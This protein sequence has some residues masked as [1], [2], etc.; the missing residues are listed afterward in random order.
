MGSRR[1]ATW[2]VVLLEE[3]LGKQNKSE[4]QVR[5]LDTNKNPGA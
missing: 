5:V 4:Q 1:G 3:E 2:T